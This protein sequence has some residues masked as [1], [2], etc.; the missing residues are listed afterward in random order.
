MEGNLKQNK[1]VGKIL[2][3]CIISVDE[4]FGNNTCLFWA[5]RKI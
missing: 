4:D 5:E 2:T 3:V 1:G